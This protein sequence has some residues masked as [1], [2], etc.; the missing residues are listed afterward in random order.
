MNVQELG[1]VAL[2]DTGSTK[3]IITT[4]L[5]RRLKLQ[6][7]L[8]SCT[9]S[10][11]SGGKASSTLQTE[12]PINTV[13]GVLQIN[14]IV[15]DLILDGVDFLIGID[16][17]NLLE[18][19][20]VCNG[21]VTFGR[22]LADV[23]REVGLMCE[24]SDCAAL[25][26]DEEDFEAYFSQGKWTAKWKWKVDPPTNFK[27][28]PNY[29]VKPH[30]KDQ[31]NEKVNEWIQNGWLQPYEGEVKATIPLM[32][33][34]QVIK[35]KV[36]PVLD[37][38]QLNEFILSYTGDSDVC[39]E[40][41]RKWRKVGSSCK[42][43]DLKDA[44]LQVHIAEELWPYQ[45]VN[46]QG[47]RYCLTR[48]GFGLNS[49][50]RIMTHI[51][52]KVLEIREEIRDATDN[53]IDDI[54]VNETNMYLQA[55]CA[56]QAVD[57]KTARVLG[58]QLTEFQGKLIWRRGNTM[59]QLGKEELSRREYFSICGKLT[60]HYPVGGWLRVACSYAKRLCNGVG[61][62]DKVGKE[63]MEVIEAIIQEVNAKDPVQGKWS[64]DKNE[65]SKCEV[66][67]DASAIATGALLCHDGMVIEDGGWLRKRDDKAHINL[68]ELDAALKGINLAIKWQFAEIELK[69]DSATVYGWI[70]SC[71]KETHKP[72]I[73]GLSEL[74]VRRRLQI[75]KELTEEY[76]LKICLELVPS[77]KNKADVLTRIAKE[78]KVKEKKEELC[79]IT[80]ASTVQEVHD[81]HH[82]GL[83]KTL[84]T[85]KRL[86]IDANQEEVMEI[87]KS[88]GRCSS[89]DPRPENW[90][91]GSLHVNNTWQ[92][93]AC[94]ITHYNHTKFLT[95]MDCGPSRFCI[96]RRV[97]NEDGTTIAKELRNI[98]FRER[99]A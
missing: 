42:M 92:R 80:C 62:N 89:I 46:Y 23:P 97:A 90:E 91:K 63:A 14:C 27:Y 45:V 98:F 40:K 99:S 48:L 7:K 70:V 31:F 4:N 15:I 30:I 44:Y 16:A 47:K 41:L 61:W 10:T 88:C 52:R 65:V 81:L 87:I 3:T 79:G 17:I 49:A 55:N 76:K 64:V 95:V 69:V 26:I 25:R 51:L 24:V 28:I 60:G 57:C 13:A 8:S 39:E 56:R 68:A 38:R 11:L 22:S 32:A 75:I 36:R 1:V 86:G 84:F 71:L 93:L 21:K 77:S 85:C 94:D 43:L 18:G 2:V 34:E 29:E 66:W 12:V 6:M 50:P 53:Y 19:V 96:W 5:C 58:L 74:L 9:I 67:T 37:Y 72:R 54:L 73:Y 78:M 33:E 35:K 82:F 59:P 83:N 20:H